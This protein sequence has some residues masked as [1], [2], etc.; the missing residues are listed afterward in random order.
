[1]FLRAECTRVYLHVYT[2][3]TLSSG[4][5]AT[6][7]A[8]SPG[9]Q[10]VYYTYTLRAAVQRGEGWPSSVTCALSPGQSWHKTSKLTLFSFFFYTLVYFSLLELFSLILYFISIALPF[11]F[12][13][14]C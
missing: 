14:L 3:H 8:M 4:A 11:P 7:S 6:I 10:N 13:P 9:V 12:T 1:M 5:V 2:E